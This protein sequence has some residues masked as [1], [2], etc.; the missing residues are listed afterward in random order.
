M[1]TILISLRDEAITPEYRD[2]IESLLPDA[3]LLITNQP[4]EIEAMLGE[5]EIAVGN[6]P[7]KWIPRA[8]NLRWLQQWGAGTDWLMKHPEIAGLDFILTN[9][10]GVHAIPISE[11]ILALMLGLSRRIPQAVR[12]QLEHRWVPNEDAFELHGK[13]LLL[14]GLG[15]IGRQTALV[16]S[17]LG[18]HVT[19][20]RRSPAKKVAGVEHLVGQKQLLQV[21]PEADFVVLTIPLTHETRHMFDAQA[22]AAMK[23]SAIIINIGRG[24]TIDE[25]ALVRALQE[26]KIAGAGLD[27]FETEPLPDSSPL[28]TMENVLITAH[29]SGST[30]HYD[31]RAFDIFIDNLERYSRGQPLRNVVDKHL[32][33]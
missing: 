15:A 23:P 7:I 13:N 5:I 30:P 24:A 28:W 4:D 14:I 11:H 3:R 20:I 12:T 26:G 1:R 2:Q 25:A 16:T 33:Y 27:V 32:G 17:A 21:L 9:A 19:G 31:Q 18:M 8:H 10:S 6:F 29:Y 22:L